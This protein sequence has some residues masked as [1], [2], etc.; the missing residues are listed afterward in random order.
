MKQL[1]LFDPII[2]NVRVKLLNRSQ[3]GIKKYG[4]T[5]NQNNKDSYLNHLQQEMMD[6]CNYI[7]K[8]IVQNSALRPSEY[9]DESAFGKTSHPTTPNSHPPL[10]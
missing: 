6:A 1:E 4:T 3:I 9:C 5:L 8:L 10:D 2:E 7:E